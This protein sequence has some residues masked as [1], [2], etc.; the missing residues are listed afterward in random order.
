MTDEVRAVVVSS[1]TGGG[2]GS[3][4]K[5]TPLEVWRSGFLTV[6]VALPATAISPALIVAVRLVEEP[7]TVVRF[8]PFHRTTAPLTKSVPVAVKVNPIPPAC[9]EVGEIWS[10]VGGGAAVTVKV[11]AFET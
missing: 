7:K 6:T 4:V 1:F 2:A 11:S 10:R 9:F 5:V 3:I 8:D